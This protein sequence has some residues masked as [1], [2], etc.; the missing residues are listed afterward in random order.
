MEL[1][2]KKKSKSDMKNGADFFFISE[3]RYYVIVEGEWREEGGFV[4][5]LTREGWNRFN[6]SENL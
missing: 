1:V 5:G 6:F 2:K 3:P 4:G